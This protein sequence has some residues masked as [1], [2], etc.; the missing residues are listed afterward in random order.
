MPQWKYVLEGM[1]TGFH[2]SNNEHKI[3]R[4]RYEIIQAQKD[5]EKP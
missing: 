5:K 2:H 4:R 3:P 1:W